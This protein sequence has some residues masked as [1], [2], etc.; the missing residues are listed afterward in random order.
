[1]Q[2]MPPN[3]KDQSAYVPIG[4]PALC[5]SVRQ[6]MRKSRENNRLRRAARAECSCPHASRAAP[7]LCAGI[8]TW[9]PLRQWKVGP[10]SRVGVIGMGGLGHMGVKLASALGARV[11]MISR[12]ADKR[13][14]ALEIGADDFLVSTN[15]AAMKAA[16][17]GFDLILDTVPVQHD[18]DTYMPLIDIDGTLVILGQ[19][20]PWGEVNGLP[21]MFGR[22]R[23]AGSPIG[24]IR[25]T[26]EVIDFCARK[27]ILPECRM[28]RAD[29]I[30]D[31]FATLERA[32]IPYRFVIDMASLSEDAA[33]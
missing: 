13:E 31:A 9:S 12:S 1:M 15:E 19:V 23:V 25:E 5:R 29:E 2:V 4:T 21:F 24:G 26:Q 20:G 27:G 32:D 33:D 7:I 18:L 3:L 17:N 30:N 10:A 22:R 6:Y 14:K 11:T 8:T 16:S 28:I